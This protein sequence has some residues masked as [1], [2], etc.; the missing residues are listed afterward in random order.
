MKVSLIQVP[1]DSGHLKQRM[2][3]GPV[4][5]VEQGLI[6]Y[7]MKNSVDVESTSINFDEKFTLEIGTAKVI[8]TLLAEKVKLARSKESLPIIL[9]GNCNTSLGTTAGLAVNDLGVIWFDAH[10]DFNTP[11]TSLS[12]FFDGMSLSVL[13]GNCWKDFAK[14]IP[15]FKHIA[16]NKI[17]LAGA[18]DIDE[19][20]E[21]LLKSS[22]ITHL[23]VNEIRENFFL[24]L[25]PASVKNA[26][27]LY[28][29][30]DLDIFDPSEL[31][32]NKYSVDGG[33]LLEEFIKIIENIRDN[34]KIAAIA[35]T[36]YDPSFDADNSAYNIVARII[37][38]AV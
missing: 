5:L 27:E 21:H 4:H 3:L 12:G 15:G 14:T 32:A 26:D 33:L 19:K 6:D 35:F 1:W 30:I 31:T 36:A 23:K 2:G 17:V 9:A 11:E 16:E 8:N 13:T 34:F 29:H 10:A 37:Q 20:E 7:L 28:I 18:R 25:L 38:L 24:S 22:S